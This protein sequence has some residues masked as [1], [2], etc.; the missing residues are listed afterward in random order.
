VK[1][2]F[3]LSGSRGL[4]VSSRN[5][6]CSA[7]VRGIGSRRRIGRLRALRRSPRDPSRPHAHRYPLSRHLTTQ[8]AK[9][10]VAVKKRASVQAKSA[11]A[12]VPRADIAVRH[13]PDSAPGAGSTQQTSYVAPTVLPQLPVGTGLNFVASLRTATALSAEHVSARRLS[14]AGTL[15]GMQEVT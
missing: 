12:Q 13:D 2:C 15:G 3:G 6:M 5:G 10:G 8:S 4:R 14:G 9:R 11:L 1:L 7:R